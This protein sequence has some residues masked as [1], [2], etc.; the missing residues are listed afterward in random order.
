MIEKINMKQQP[1]S[2]TKSHSKQHKIS[3]PSMEL[4]DLNH[5]YTFTINLSDEFETLTQ[6]V[7]QYK[8]FCKK[9]I[10]PYSEFQLYAELSKLGR[11]HYHGL[12]KFVEIEKLVDFYFS[13]RELYPLVAMEIDTISDPK[14]WD[15]YIFKQQKYMGVACKLKGIDYCLNNKTCRSAKAI[16]LRDIF[17]DGAFLEVPSEALDYGVSP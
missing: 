2:Y 16:H 10:H 17:A 12:I 14:K 3:V 15:D 11:L 5:W 7:D 13:L 6:N 8:Y 4:I 1:A 9:Y